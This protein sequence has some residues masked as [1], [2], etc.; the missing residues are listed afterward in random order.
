MNSG[1]GQW[2]NRRPEMRPVLHREAT[3][4]LHQLCESYEG[5]SDEQ[6]IEKMGSVV[7]RCKQMGFY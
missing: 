3:E 6:F 2:F 5:D 7:K 4:L 1:K